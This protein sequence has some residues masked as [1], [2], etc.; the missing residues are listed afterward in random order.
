MVVGRSFSIY[1]LPT[2]YLIA[3]YAPEKYH[4]NKSYNV[5]TT[6]PTRAV[7]LLHKARPSTDF[8]KN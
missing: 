5:I 1:C 4:Q 3:S 6:A 2:H 8:F 7:H